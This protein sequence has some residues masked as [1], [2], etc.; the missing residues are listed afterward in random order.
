MCRAHEFVSDV[1]QASS[2]QLFKQEV[3]AECHIAPSLLKWI[4]TSCG[5]APVMS[6]LERWEEESKQERKKRLAWRKLQASISGVLQR[7][8]QWVGEREGKADIQATEEQKEHTH[9]CNLI[10]GS[11]RQLTSSS[12]G[13]ETCTSV[14]VYRALREITLLLSTKTTLT[15]KLQYMSTSW[16]DVQDICEVRLET[17]WP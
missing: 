17:S 12:K 2:G 10:R 15:T 7:E 13:P 9:F 14:H 6:R 4:W 1:G 16:L 5:F 11:S 8:T 3:S